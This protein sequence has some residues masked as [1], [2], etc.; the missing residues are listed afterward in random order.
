MEL[1]LPLVFV[2]GLALGMVLGWRARC[3]V[4]P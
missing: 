2:S 1:V 3:D 4:I